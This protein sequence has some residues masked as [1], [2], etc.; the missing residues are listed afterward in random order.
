MSTT[1]G[2]T[3]IAGTPIGTRAPKIQQRLQ[4]HQQQQGRQ[5]PK[6]Q[7]EKSESHGHLQL[8]INADNSGHQQK[9]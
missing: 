9:Q 6:R 8:Q 4:K 7:R 1:E 3:S 2:M 5:Q